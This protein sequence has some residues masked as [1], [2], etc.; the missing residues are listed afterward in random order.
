MI[1]KMIKK[2]FLSNAMMCAMAFVGVAGFFGCSS[3]DEVV[4]VNPTYNPKT[5]E[6]VV[7]LALSVS[8]ANEP[9]TRMTSAATQAT[10]Q[11]EFRGIENAC[12]ATFKLSDDGK[13]VSS[14][15]TAP[16]LISLGSILSKGQLNNDDSRR[17]LELSMGTGTN[18]LAFWAKAIKKGTDSGEGKVV[19]N[20]EQ[21][22]ANTS[23]SLSP[24]LSEDDE[25]AFSDYQ[26]QIANALTSI[27]MSNITEVTYNSTTT[28]V[29]ISF[30]DY[31]KVTKN[32]E[33]SYELSRRDDDPSDPSGNL[34]MCDLGD[35]LSNAFVTLNTIHTSELRD[36]SGQAVVY[37][38][39]DLMSAVN[40]VIEATPASLQEA[41]AQAVAVKIKEN[42]EAFFDAN[43][44]YQ[45]K[46]ASL[47]TFPTDFNLPAGS[48]HL[49]FV[50]E[51]K[52]ATDAS[53]GYNFSYAY[54]TANAIYTVGGASEQINFFEPKN[55][56]YPAELCYFGNSPIRV[57]DKELVASNY[58]NGAAA[59]ENDNSW[60]S[61]DWSAANKH[62]LA[63][64]RSVAM[65]SN[66]NYGTALLKT[67]VRY[68]AT[69]LHDNN[70][71]LQQQ[72]NDTE[73]DD[74]EIEADDDR[75]LLTG[76]LV[77]GQ[78]QEVGWNYIAKSA[79][80]TF[81]SVVYDK[82]DN[83]S[84]PK[85]TSSTVANNALSDA[86]YTL[87]WDNWDEE[88]K[89]SKQ[90]DVYIALEFKNNGKAFYGE[91]NLIRSEGTFYLI[92]KLDP[93]AKGSTTDRSDGIDWPERYA[94]PP[95]DADGKT[96]KERR[97]FMQDYMTAA[98][99]VIGE[100]SLQH[101]LVTVPDMRSGQI[102]LGLSVDLEWRTGL[103][104]EN[105]V[106]GGSN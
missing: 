4:D 96:V 34:Q 39:S 20:V 60:N 105:V 14:A 15:V 31:A 90:R 100:T 82:V 42:V 40:S 9:Q 49:Q 26:T 70:K 69:T 18:A 65:G 92:G 63:T 48:V 38:I 8:T 33:E 3:E 91:S 93:D 6:V 80:P 76:V 75:F 24:I 41:I 1:S 88:H 10:K 16:K 84:V 2:S 7:D 11:D 5:G 62:V 36:G 12:L 86:N 95:Y 53:Q 61:N 30:G 47:N 57:T 28:N 85:A 87:L 98:T 45:W 46:T 19:W 64:T 13:P 74:N 23:F 35:K 72:W 43:N 99:F 29:A 56:M 71:K 94:L 101:A 81:S 21:N 58:P 51:P 78:E 44:G 103:S 55:F 83:I 50:V 102:S 73:A 67:Q 106:L 68:G 25:T 66:I 22:L 97:V 37:M 17:V 52:D 59:W 54:K 32:G 89:G 104:F 79:S 77:G 27:M